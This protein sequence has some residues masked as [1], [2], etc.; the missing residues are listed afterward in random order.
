MQ[1]KKLTKINKKLVIYFC[2]IL[3][4][5]NKTRMFK[6]HMKCRNMEQKLFSILR[7]QILRFELCLHFQ[8]QRKQE[9]QFFQLWNIF[10]KVK[11]FSEVE[12][13]FWTERFRVKYRKQR[14]LVPSMSSFNGRVLVHHSP[15]WNVHSVHTHI[16]V[17]NPTSEWK[18]VQSWP[19]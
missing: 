13:F 12:N 7:L 4:E 11:R 18:K 1:I 2:K 17:L 5:S 15:G 6:I 10:L 3:I 19:H 14:I 9:K 16:W 8:F